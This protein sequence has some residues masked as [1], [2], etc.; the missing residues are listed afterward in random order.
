[1]TVRVDGLLRAPSGESPRP[2]DAADVPAVLH[3]P[4][5]LV[6]AVGPLVDVVVQI[7][8]AAAGHGNGASIVRR[9]K[10]KKPA[11]NVLNQAG[12][13]LVYSDR[14]RRVPR[15]DGHSARPQTPPLH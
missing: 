13:P 2:R 14:G 4:L 7:A 6:L 12:L 10:P 5:P 8:N 15:H 11:T 3:A 1:M 9:R